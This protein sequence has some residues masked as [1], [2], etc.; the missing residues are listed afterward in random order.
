MISQLNAMRKD[1]TILKGKTRLMTR[2]VRSYFLLSSTIPILCRSIPIPISIVNCA[3][4]VSKDITCS[5]I[6]PSFIQI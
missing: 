5:N 1:W 4:S 3:C 6:L 2:S